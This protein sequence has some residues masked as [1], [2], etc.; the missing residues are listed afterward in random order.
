M[1]GYT[2]CVNGEEL[3][4]EQAGGGN[5]DG[6]LWEA[7]GNPVAGLPAAVE[8]TPCISN[9]MRYTGADARIPEGTQFPTMTVTLEPVAL[10]Q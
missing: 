5:A 4:L 2:I 9:R 3:L 8:I 6:F 1:L 7:W 10:A